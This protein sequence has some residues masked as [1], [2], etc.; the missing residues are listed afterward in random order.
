MLAALAVGLLISVRQQTIGLPFLIA[1]AAGSV[2]VTILVEARGLM[3]TVGQLPLLFGISLPLTAWMINA[4]V[5]N[6][7]Q[8]LSATTILTLVYPLAQHFPTLGLVTLGCAIIAALRI[9]QFRRTMGS[10]ARSA[11]RERRKTQEADR[12]NR[13]TAS[14]AR[15]LSNRN[16]QDI[17]PHKEPAAASQRV[18]VEE[19]QRR[20]SAPEE[21]PQQPHKR[22]VQRPRPQQRPAAQQPHAAPSTPEQPKRTKPQSPPTMV[23]SPVKASPKTGAHHN[24]HAVPPRPPSNAMLNAVR[25]S[26]SVASRPCVRKHHTKSTPAKSALGNSHNVRGVSA[27]PLPTLEA[28]GQ[29][30]RLVAMTSSVPTSAQCRRRGCSNH[31][32]RR[33]AR[34]HTI[35]APAVAGTRRVVANRRRHEGSASVI[36]SNVTTVSRSRG[37]RSSAASNQRPMRNRGSRGLCSAAKCGRSSRAVIRRV[38]IVAVTAATTTCIN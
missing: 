32:G 29:A 21:P 22:T 12:T 3:L 36:S 28:A 11:E 25:L 26:V 1:F 8:K 14:R 24:L 23:I 31:S 9:W 17:P 7:P 2:V 27:D 18:T 4:S 13:E 37:S 20:A 16:Q 15:R 33:H 19:L 34:R 38:G 35:T 30:A 10:Q 5:S 6:V